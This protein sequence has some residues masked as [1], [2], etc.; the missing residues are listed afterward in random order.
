MIGKALAAVL[1]TGRAPFNQRFR[2]AQQQHRGLDAGAWLAW[3]KDTLDPVAARVAAHDASAVAPVVDV[4]YDQA[5]LLVAKN[6]LGPRA[7]DPVLAAA[8]RELLV[9]LAPALARE[10][11]RLSGSLLNALHQLCRD[12]PAR[13]RHWSERLA[14]LGAGLTDVDA[15]LGL[16]RMLA[17][18]AGWPAQR[19][20]AL[21]VAPR[22]PPALAQA[23]LELSA[24]PG[25]SLWAALTAAPTLRAD[26]V[27]LP[28]ARDL[29]WLG[30]CGGFRGLGGPFARL[31]SVGLAAG[32]LAASDGMDTW[33][34]AGDG[35]GTQ[36]LRMGAGA[37]WPVAPA[38]SRVRVSSTGTVTAG[39]LSREFP[40]LESAAAWAWHA[41]LLAVTLRTSYQVALLRC[42]L[43]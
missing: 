16:G 2:A 10:P 15:I 14:Q 30:W 28:V 22:L 37:D 40:D 32:Q 27:G 25:P 36:A 7:R 21:Q 19:A 29:S 5:L 8:Y 1:Q 23:A 6:W 38:D 34:L 24:P 26:E 11:A 43:P 20:A 39:A 3:M 35:Y 17:W 31:P 9:G 41:G 4:L 12:D 13:A 18:R 42:P 33:R